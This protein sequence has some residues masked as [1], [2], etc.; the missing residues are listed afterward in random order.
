MKKIAL[1][2]KEITKYEGK[3]YFNKSYPD[4]VKLRKLDNKRINKLGWKATINLKTGLKTYC[5]YFKNQ[6][7]KNVN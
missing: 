7:V 6:V 5:N 2:I 3:I 4:G 1:L